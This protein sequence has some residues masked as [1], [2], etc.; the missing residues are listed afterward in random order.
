MAE[1]MR[2]QR[3]AMRRDYCRCRTSLQF[4]TFCLA[5][6]RLY[7]AAFRAGGAGAVACRIEAI[8]KEIVS[9]LESR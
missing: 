5:W 8:H 3:E 2:L 1:Y 6:A 4:D 7:G 9:I